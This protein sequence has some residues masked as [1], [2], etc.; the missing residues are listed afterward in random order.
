[1]TIFRGPP[2]ESEEGIGALTLPGFLAEVAT[3]HAAREAVVFHHPEGSVT[4]WTYRDLDREARRVAKALIAADVDKGSRVALLLGNR[5]EW[6]AAAYGTALAGGVVVPVNTYCEPPELEYVLRHSDAAIVLTQLQLAG[7][8]Y[9][10]QIR[11]MRPRLPYL[12]EVVALDDSW[13]AFL[14]AGKRVADE[15]V[16]ARASEVRPADPGLIVYTSGTTAVPKGIL[17]A[18]RGPALQ[19]WRFVR[20][21]CLDP[22]DRVWSAFPFFWSAGFAMVMG[23]TLAA[24][25]CLVLEERFA[26]AEALR[27][28]ETERVTAPFAWPHQS[29]EMEDHPAWHEADLSSIVKVTEFSSFARHPTVHVPR[30]WSSFAAYGLSETCTVITSLP[31]DTPPEEQEGCEGVILPGNEVR[32][33]HPDTG[34]AL[35]SGEI[36]RIA[37]RGPTLMEG[38]VKM[39]H[40]E[41]FDA[42]GFF[43]T[44]DAGYVDRERK[45]HWTGRT[46]EMIKTGGANVSPWEIE[47][48]LMHHPALKAAKAVGLPHPTLGEMV[49]VCAVVHEDAEVDEHEVRDFLRGTLAV[50]KIPRHVVFVG[51]EELSLTA[52][53]KIRVEALRGLA[54]ERLEKE[55]ATQ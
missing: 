2:L 49:V 10:E 47:L 38:Y 29:A 44:S 20:H 8:R 15:V 48:A 1:M 7:H 26:P 11:P 43:H 30:P 13:D 55:N 35:G 51:H 37:V 18:H 40:E 19:S 52:N 5:P 53:A 6:V 50:Y 41:C 4:R 3:R 36:G 46:S 21:L 33:L 22:D 23:G 31:A 42:D 25:G 39:L 14:A 17:H 54:L 45:F 9:L 32:I 16:D 28:I 27:L 12:R 24:G 34:G